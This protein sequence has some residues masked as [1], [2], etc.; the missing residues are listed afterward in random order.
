MIKHILWDFD[1]TLF[2]T[3]PAK[4]Y[5]MSRTMAELGFSIPLN[6]IDGLIRQSYDWCIECL[7]KRYP[8]SD[9]EV[10]EKFLDYYAAIPYKNQILFPGV[11]EVCSWIARQGG[12]NWIITDREP[13]ECRRFLCEH[14]ADPYFDG[15]G[16]RPSGDINAIAQA[17]VALIGRNELEHE[18]VL[19]VAYQE[20]TIRAAHQL[21]LKTCRYGADGQITLADWQVGHYQRLLTLLE[22]SS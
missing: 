9:Q 20:Q 3:S 19:V 6:T 1:G 8:F 11:I 12:S 2:D 22:Q 15:V 14:A 18:A 13:E 7:G 4:T 21:G 17:L 10:R 5:A 16:A